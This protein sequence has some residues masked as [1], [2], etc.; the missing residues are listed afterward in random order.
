MRFALSPRD[1]SFNNLSGSVPETFLR[2]NKLYVFKLFID[3]LYSWETIVADG[4][5]FPA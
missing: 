2:L 4:L 5:K 3:I 1:L